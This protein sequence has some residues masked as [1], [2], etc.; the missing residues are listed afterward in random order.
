MSP[1]GGSL[2]TNTGGEAVTRDAGGSS[3][4]TA[5]GGST[6]NDATGGSTAD[7]SGSSNGTSPGIGGAGPGGRSGSTGGSGTGGISGWTGGTSTGGFPGSTGLASGGGP[8]NTTGGANSGGMSG[9]AG[10]LGSGDVP[11]ATGGVG[12]GGT[13]GAVDEDTGGVSGS[14]GGA[15][16]VTDPKGMTLYYVRHG[17]TLANVESGT[18]PTDLETADTLT[19]LGL[20]QIEALKTYLLESGITPDAVLVSPAPRTQ[21]TIEPYLVASNLTGVIWPELM[22]CCGEDPTGEPLPTEPTRYEFWSISIEAENLVL[23]D[24]DPGLFWEMGTYEQGLYMVMQARDALLSQYGQTGKT[25]LITGHAIAGSML[26]GLLRG[27]D[28]TDGI[29]QTGPNAIYM[30]NTGVL[31]AV[32]DPATGLF[33]VEGTNI[34]NPPRE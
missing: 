13:S 25:V 22:E 10:G 26:V 20:Q 5:A 29:E 4:S 11:D 14:A 9:S 30:L 15:A 12:T 18:T 34:N 3:G 2:A 31:K 19:D 32:Q 17:E 21:K 24:G 23:R 6:A 8:L 33:E 28:M 27:D 16:S 1:S 7:G